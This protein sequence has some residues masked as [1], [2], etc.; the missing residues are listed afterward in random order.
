MQDSGDELTEPV[1]SFDAFRQAVVTWGVPRLRDLPWR[2]TRDPWAVLVSEVMLQQTQAARVIPKWEAFLAEFPDPAA[3][4]AAPL[5]AVLRAWQGLGY[6]R[7]AKHL[8]ATAVAIVTERDG[9]WPDEI[10]ALMALPGIGPYTARAVRAF[11]HELPAAVVDTNVARILARVTG[12][13]L[14]ASRA[15]QLADRWADDD[16]PWT[17]NQVLLDLGA[18]VCRP[19]PNCPA[20][21][22]RSWC[23]WHRSGVR[24]PIL[25]SARL[26]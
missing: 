5:G 8:H 4:A 21:P 13:R 12:A 25:R 22:I 20:C 17:W 9:R 19:R 7:R 26:G 6:P 14:T 16:E 2:R 23:E 24:S 18:S 10:D 11:A 15:Q 1:E 3:C